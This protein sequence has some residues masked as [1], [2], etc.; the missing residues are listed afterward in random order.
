MGA[1]CQRW[2]L[3][4]V[5][6]ESVRN[7]ISFGGEFFAGT[8]NEIDGAG[9]WKTTNGTDWERLTVPFG[10][11]ENMSVCGF[12]VFNGY[13]YIGLQRADNTAQSLAHTRWLF[14]GTRHH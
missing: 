6:A 7:L 11:P 8:Y 9:L 5:N 12:T 1:D 13:L 3:G 4:N 14:L 2:P 10:S